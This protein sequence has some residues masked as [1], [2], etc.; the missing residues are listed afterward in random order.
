MYKILILHISFSLSTY[1][2]IH[3]NIKFINNNDISMFFHYF[4]VCNLLISSNYFLF[5]IFQIT[6]E[7]ESLTH[8]KTPTY[9][10][11]TLD[12]MLTFKSHCEK[13]AKKINTRNC[14]IRNLTGSIWGAQPHAIRVSALALCFSVGKYGCPVW[15]RSIHTGKVDVALN[16][17]CRIITWCLK[18]TPVKK[19]YLLAGV[20]PPNIRRLVIT[21]L[22]T[23]K[24]TSD[25][26][27]L[28]FRLDMSI[29]R[30]KARKSF[31]KTSEI[32]TEDPSLRKITLWR[33]QIVVTSWGMEPA[34]Q[35]SPGHQ[36]EWETWRTLNRMRV[37]VGRSKDNM[38]RWVYLN[39]S[40]TKC[41]CGQEQTMAHLLVCPKESQQMH[42]RW[43]N[44]GKWKSGESRSVLDNRRDIINV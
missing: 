41:R 32:L 1:F 8:C 21:N 6:W 4:T 27:H 5:Q 12:R 16:N 37:G 42:G 2:C 13:T 14:L 18:S 36:L 23:C 44:T 9:L 20:A 25:K 29:F 40:D 11:V 35:L 17:S 34:E 33:D 24:Q 28:M 31:L 43:P 10:G 30:L 19:V 26:R 38:S 15:G 22:E 7:G 3:S 39:D